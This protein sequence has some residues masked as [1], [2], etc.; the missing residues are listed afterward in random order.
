LLSA[1]LNWLFIIYANVA[2]KDVVM[3]LPWLPFIPMHLK[4]SLL[5]ISL[6]VL[7]LDGTF[8]VVNYYSSRDALYANLV[9]RAQKQQKEFTFALQMTYRNMMQ[10]SE[11]VSANDELNQIFLKGK[12]A[13]AAEGGGGGGE[14]AQQFRQELLQKV[15]PSWDKLMRDFDV[16]QL[17]YHLGPGSLSFLRVHKPL[18]YGDRLDDIRHTI[19]D[20]NSEKTARSG[21]ETG[22]IYSGLRS[23]LPIWTLDPDSQQQVYVGALE[24]G[25]SFDQLLPLFAKSHEVSLAV[26][27]S[28][29]HVESK[30][31]PEFIAKYFAENPDIGYYLESSSSKL[32]SSE[33]TFILHNLTV[34]NKYVT[35]D[36]QLLNTGD[37]YLSAYYFPLRDYKGEQ[38]HSLDPAGLVLIWEDVTGLI[39]AFRTAVWVNVLYAVF[40][41]ILFEV[42]LIWFFKREV[43]LAAAEK[44]ATRDG[45]TGS[46]NRRYFESAFKKELSVARRFN[47]DMALIMCDVDYFKQ[48]NDR[49]GHPAGDRCLIAIATALELVLNRGSDW[50]ARYGGEEFVIVLPGTDLAGA[51]LVAHKVRAAVAA[52]NITQTDSPV[53]SHVTM[54]LGVSS[55]RTL[56][57]TEELV[58]VA[59]RHLYRAKEQGRNGIHFG[60]TDR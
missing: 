56:A 23:V 22:R 30:M 34:T 29:S 15:Q 11:F 6:I 50:L 4:R 31:W 10:I 48:Y 43:K 26:L 42:V 9:D 21:F 54:S 38:D 53:A 41:F 25:A 28:K 13:V 36:V 52:L 20:T 45:L 60:G 17:H 58:D 24:V 33:V 2:V 12:K 37:G 44:Q 19:V 16:R 40:G 49:Y 8:V 55:L 39:S 7:S 18:K 46:Y 3:R 27:L 59:D 51:L 47:Q 5:F 57:A 35:Q 32:A 1:G 14:M